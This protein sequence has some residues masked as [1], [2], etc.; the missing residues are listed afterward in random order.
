MPKPPT[1]IIVSMEPGQGGGAVGGDREA[2]DVAVIGGGPAGAQCALW[3]TKLGL[4]T[5]LLEKAGYLGGLQHLSPAT[6]SWLSVVPS[7]TPAKGI[8]AAI[9]ANL[10]AQGVEFRLGEAARVAKAGSAFEAAAGGIAVSARAVVLAT[11]TRHR[12]SGAEDGVD[13][14]AGLQHAWSFDRKPCRV[15]V[16]G[17]GDAAFEAYSVLSG[18][19][20]EVAVFARTVHARQ[21]LRASVPSSALFGEGILLRGKMAVSHDGG[22]WPFDAAIVLH[23]WEAN[24]PDMEGISLDLG[25]DGYVGVDWNFMTAEPGLF[26]VG[27]MVRGMHPCVATALGSAAQAAKAIERLLAGR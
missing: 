6:N 11:G 4:R 26:A 20:H 7:D 13:V 15:A 1:D 5:V 8:A 16:S 24:L 9:A 22:E 27:D 18:K 19:G 2:I 23:G 17:G 3:L 21:E 10:E 25:N 14:L 12:V